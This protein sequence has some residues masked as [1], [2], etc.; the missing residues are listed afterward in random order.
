MNSTKELRYFDRYEGRLKQE[1]IYGEKPLRWAY[2]T[3]LGRACLEGIIKR[4]WFSALYGSWAD[5][6]SSV[7]EVSHFIERFGVDTSEFLN[8]PGTFRTFNEFFY[9]KLKP[10]A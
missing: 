7:K 9:R 3:A 6:R 5:S 1:G 2:E 10:E 8:A 4:P